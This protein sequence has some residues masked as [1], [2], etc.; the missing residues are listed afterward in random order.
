MA[1]CVVL[2]KVNAS[3][4]VIFVYLWNEELLEHVQ[5]H[6]TSNGCLHEEKGAKEAKHV[7]LLA[8]T[9]MFQE[10]TW[11]FAAPNPAVVDIDMKRALITDSRNLSTTCIR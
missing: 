10:D 4:L 2:L 8:L 9:N 3:F 6:D 11:I 7:H 1:R 5:T